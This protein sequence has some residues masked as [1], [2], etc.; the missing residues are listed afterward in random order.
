MLD[1][2]NESS[3]SPMERAFR[4]RRQFLTRALGLT[5]GAAGLAAVGPAG[6]ALAQ[7]AVNDPA[8]LNFA[9]NL[10]YL[11]AEFY[12]Y[13]VYGRGLTEM[14]YDTS[15]AG[16]AG[17]TRVKPNPAVPFANDAIRQYATEIAQDELNH[18]L[19]LRAALQAAGI[20]PV[21]RPSLDLLNSF[22]TAAQ[23]AGIGG[24]FDPFASD[25]AFLIGSFVFE[26][27][28]V[29]AY[30]GA[31][32]LIKNKDYLD[33][34]AGILAVEAYHAA[35]VRTLLYAN[36]NVA[37]GGSTVGAIVKALSDLRAA[38]GGGADQSIEVNGAANIVPTDGNSIAFGR[39]TSQVLN[40][41]Y[42]GATQTPFG[43]FP[44]R[45]NGAIR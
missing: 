14:G 27:V 38:A 25:L 20:Q 41:V 33:A 30:H 39:T 17:T 6:E 29:T 18:V 16:T 9:L 13:A 34:A 12:L 24:S 40:I 32:R 31:A 7:A 37:L 11:E 5:A 19:F 2:T 4:P 36:R 21:A 3:G 22:N 43:F 15:G 44:N 8:I 42:L 23:A 45:M 28:G 10:E 35:E 1:N 26:D